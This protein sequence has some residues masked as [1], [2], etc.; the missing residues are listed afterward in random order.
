MKEGD[1]II[2]I[3]TDV[4]P[5]NGIA[6]PLKLEKE[7]TIR[8]VIQDSKGNPHFDVG[9][10]SDL[11]TISSWDTGELLPRGDKIHWCHPS[12]FRRKE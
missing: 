3:K 12:R 4:L 9:L 1:T 7:Y 10:P 8:E 11:F 2:C 6:P 5:G